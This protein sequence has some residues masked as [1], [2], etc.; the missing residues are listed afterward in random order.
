MRLQVLN[1]KSLNVVLF[2]SLFAM[3]GLTNAGS[4]GKVGTGAAAGLGLDAVASFGSKLLNSNPGQAAQTRLAH[5]LSQEGNVTFSGNFET[6]GKIEFKS[7]TAIDG[8]LVSIGDN[9]F[10]DFKGTNFSKEIEVDVEDVKS[11]GGVIRIATNTHGGWRVGD[12]NVNAEIVGGD[13]TAENGG[14]VSL[15]NTQ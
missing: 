3:S 8:G 2:T 11:V 14:M 9:T 12:I 7:I 6:N 4:L 1:K 10:N 15:F 5:E 13:V